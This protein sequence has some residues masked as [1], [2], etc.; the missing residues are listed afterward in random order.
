MNSNPPTRALSTFNS[1]QDQPNEETDGVTTVS[2]SFNSIQDQQKHADECEVR[3]Q[4]RLSILSKINPNTPVRHGDI[5]PTFQFYP[6][7]T[8][9]KALLRQHDS[10]YFQFYPRST[11]LVKSY[12]LGGPDDFQFYPRST[13]SGHYFPGWG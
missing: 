10:S 2:L 5:E 11:K 8:E 12:A 6:R 4:N 9:K 13:G 3:T 7:S 1:I